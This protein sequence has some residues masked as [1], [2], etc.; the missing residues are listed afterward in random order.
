[1]WHLGREHSRQREKYNVCELTVAQEGYY[2]G[3]VEKGRVLGEFSE[4]G[5]D[6]ITVFGVL[7]RIK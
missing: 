5:L 6:H 4:E 7:L 1:M 3:G 2:S